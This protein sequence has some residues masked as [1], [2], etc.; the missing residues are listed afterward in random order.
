MPYKAGDMLKQTLPNGKEQY[1]T[2]E[3]VNLGATGE[4][5]VVHM[6][7]F[8]RKNTIDGLQETISVPANMVDAMVE[9][10]ILVCIVKA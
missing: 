7:A 9:E 10:E 4:I 5:G 2:I 3:S 1:Y 8:D 6:A